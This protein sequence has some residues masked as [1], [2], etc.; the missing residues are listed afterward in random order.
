MSDTVKQPETLDD[1]RT[2]LWEQ[3]GGENKRITD[4]LCRQENGECR[5]VQR[6][7]LCRP[8]ARR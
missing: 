2:L 7:P 6:N 1:I 3:Y 4:D 5:H 8:A